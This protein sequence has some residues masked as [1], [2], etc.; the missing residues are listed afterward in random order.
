MLFFIENNPENR[1]AA[2]GQSGPNHMGLIFQI[3]ATTSNAMESDIK[4]ES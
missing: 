1:K 2:V 3:W 4:Y